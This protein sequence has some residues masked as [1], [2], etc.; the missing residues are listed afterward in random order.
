MD[1]YSHELM[2]INSANLAANL[3][4]V[5]V[6][7]E[8]LSSGKSVDAQIIQLLERILEEVKRI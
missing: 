7:E 5:R 2:A 4:N 1:A 8:I 3:E 6:N